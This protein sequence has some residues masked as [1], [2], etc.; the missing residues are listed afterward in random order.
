[1]LLTGPAT[2][3]SRL[4]PPFPAQPSSSPPI[5]L[6][7]LSPLAPL[8]ASVVGPW[9]DFNSADG[10]RGG[11]G[12]VCEA[13]DAAGAR[14]VPG[15]SARR[16]HVVRNASSLVCDVATNMAVSDVSAAGFF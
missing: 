4:P 10:L 16:A 3:C 12:G 14:S 1:M 2:R 13:G 9:A 8:L 6:S 11:A 15:C 5:A 7:T